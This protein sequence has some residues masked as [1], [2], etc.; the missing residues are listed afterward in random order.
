MPR[1][2]SGRCLRSRQNGGRG[3]RVAEDVAELLDE[4]AGARGTSIRLLCER[5]L[6]DGVDATR[7]R[8]RDLCGARDR[9]IE[10]RERLRHRSLGCVR[11]LPGE[12]L[13][14]DDTERVAV[15]RRGRRLASG[16]LGREVPGGPENRPRKGQGVEA[17]RG[18]DAEVGD[19]H[20]VLVVQQQVRRLHVPMDDALRVCG[21]QAG[22]G[23]AEPLDRAARS[24]RLGASTVVDGA[25]VE[26]L[27]DDERL[28]V[29]LADV[30]DRH[31]VRM[32]RETRRGARLTRE[33]RA[34]VRVA[35]VP[36]GEHLDR[37]RSAEETV[38]RAVDVS[39]PAA[40][41]M[42]DRGVARRQGPIGHA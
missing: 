23:L 25:A 12:Q 17:G 26:V 19:V 15:A 1:R 4:L 24:D 42:R 36:L 13:V 20:A 32:R 28:A 37:D 29:V 34:H 40:R 16:L 18:R 8:R 14:R 35:R 30:E 27:H 9:R 21:V 6:E 10:M 11:P 38:G 7:K 22:R 33:A 3:L 39:H 41:E 5:S 31:D 2:R